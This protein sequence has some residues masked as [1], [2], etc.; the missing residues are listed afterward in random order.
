MSGT[1]FLLLMVIMDNVASISFE[2]RQFGPS[3]VELPSGEVRGLLVTFKDSHW[4]PVEVYRG[5]HYGSLGNEGASFNTQWNKTMSANRWANVCPQV[6]IGGVNSLKDLLKVLPRVRV[7]RLYHRSNYTKNQM[8]DCLALNVFL[9]SRDWTDTTPF[10]VMVFVHGESYEI[11]TGNAYDGSVLASYGDVIVITINYRLGVLG[12]LNT[13]H[14]T[15]QGNQALMDI[16]A[17]L[18]WVQDNI[19]AFN[20]D[21]N[22]VTLFGHGHGAALVNILTFSSLT[23]QGKYFQRAV[24]QSGS[25]LSP[26]AVSYDAHSCA[27]WLARNVNCSSF[28]NDIEGLTKCL[29]SRSAQ[30]LVNS[31]P[32]APKYH[33][34]MAPSPNPYGEIFRAPVEKLMKES[35]NTFTSIPVIFGV[36]SSEAYMYLKQKELTDGISEQRKS[37]IIRTFVLNNFQYNRQKIFDIL[38]HQYTSWDTVQTE[39]TRRDNILQ[40]LS[41]GLYVA[42][43]VKMAQEHSLSTD[44]Y[45]YAF[46]HATVSDTAQY[47]NWTSAVHGDELAYIFGA[48]LV[49]GVTPFS[50]KFTPQEKVISQTMMRYWTNFAKT[51]D[52]NKPDGELTFEQKLRSDPGWPKYN[53]SEQSFLHFGSNTTVSSHYRGKELSLW[54]DLIPKLNK[55]AKPNPD[56]REHELRD[57][58]NMA[59]FDEPHR[60]I[61][62]FKK[63]FPPH[64]PIPPPTLPPVPDTHYPN[65]D[66]TYSNPKTKRE[67]PLEQIKPPAEER[68][69]QQSGLSNSVPLSITVAIGC[70]LLFVNILLFSAV[71]Y[72]RRRIQRLNREAIEQEQNDDNDFPDIGQKPQKEN[73]AIK[74]PPDRDSSVDPLSKPN[75]QSNPLYTVISK[76]PCDLAQESS[77]ESLSTLSCASSGVNQKNAVNHKSGVVPALP[78]DCPV[79]QKD[80]IPNSKYAANSSLSKEKMNNVRNS[81][82]THDTITVV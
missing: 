67:D 21:P 42:A 73:S 61:T 77:H 82:T 32:A 50:D 69:E 15:A 54:L 31:S 68:P 11:G 74:E 13:G 80:N 1:S 20:G 60:L 38:Y 57:Q 52:P 49:E 29:R 47:H 30:D 28:T 34:C 4:T 66:P 24:I 71:Y 37:Q 26:W 58:N 17:V 14:S 43:L 53:R 2:I 27:Q 5:L 46:T 81:T 3:T 6:D 72:Q 65:G 59:S 8:E 56:P 64:P 63:I 33:S 10:A 39:F 40:L 19:R 22:K 35:R 41:D 76:T 51:G 78:R 25:A 79:I 48:P 70:S 12:F 9:P 23:E 62:N 45:L 18:Q 44:T 7:I 16:L 55:P 75:I 36:T